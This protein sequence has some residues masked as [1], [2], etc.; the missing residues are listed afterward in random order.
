MGLQLDASIPIPDADTS[1]YISVPYYYDFA[2]AGAARRGR[3]LAG[4]DSARSGLYRQLEGYLA[5]VLQCH[6]RRVEGG[7]CGVQ[8]V[9]ARAPGA[10]GHDCLLR[11]MCEASAAPLHQEVCPHRTDDA[12]MYSE[13]GLLGD[14]VNFLLTANYAGYEKDDRFQSYRAAQSR[15]Q[16]L[17]CPVVQLYCTVVCSWPG[18]ALSTTPPA[19]SPSSPS[20]PAARSS[21]PPRC[22]CSFYET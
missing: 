7:D 8:V 1:I 6:G 20:S 2:A 12:L 22:C 11:A 10:G 15:G 3:S 19:R 14:A 5:Q 18:T 13:Q 21:Q 17:H 9:G 4:G 16:V